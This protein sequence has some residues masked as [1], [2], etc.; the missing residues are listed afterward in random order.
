MEK[1][2]NNIVNNLKIFFEKTGFRRGVVGLS[3]GVDSAV[4]FSLAVEALGRNNVTALILPEKGL[5]KD[6]NITNAIALARDAGVRYENIDI[7]PFL[8]KY[9]DLPWVQNEISKMNLK[10][11]VRMCLLYNYA[12]SQETFVLGTSNKSEIMVGYGTKYGDLAADVEV[13]G[14]LYK[15]EVYKLARHLNIPKYFIETPPSAELRKGQTDE[16]EMGISYKNLDAI[17]LQIEEGKEDQTNPQVKKV[18]QM[19]KN[20]RHKSK[21][22]PLIESS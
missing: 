22:P 14:S 16:D 1:I 8:L 11:R 4:T 13:I 21:M 17:L 20:N 10:A 12:N 2:H 9:K 19:I 5:T 6:S 18:L 3:G 7:V 15:K